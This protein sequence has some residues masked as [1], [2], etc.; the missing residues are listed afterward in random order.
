MSGAPL[1]EVSD[2]PTGTTSSAPPVSEEQHSPHSYLE[3]W[4]KSQSAIKRHL[5]R[6]HE[7]IHPHYIQGDLYTGATRAFWFDSLSAFYPGLLTLMGEVDEA[8]E[9]HLLTTALWNRYSALPERWSTSSGAVEGGLAWWSGRPEFIESTYHLYRATLDPWYLHVGEMTLRDIKRRCW[10]KCGW[11]GI[12]DVRT[13][14][15]SDRMESFFL[16]ETAKY[17]FLLFDPGHPLNKLDAPFVFSTEGHPLILPKP[18]SR[19]F[20]TPNRNPTQPEPLYD[21]VIATCPLPPPS[22]PFSTSATAARKDLY[23]AA[24]LARLHLMPTP[25]TVESPIVEYSRDHPS[26]SVSDIRSPSNYTYFPWTLPLELVPHDGMCSKITAKTSFDITF[27]SSPNTVLGP[28]MLQRVLNGV[29]VNSMGGVR[30]G[31]IQDVPT[32]AGSELNREV[33]RVHAIN[34]ILLGKDERVFLAKDTAS[35]VVSPLDPNFTRVRDPLMLDIV[36]D[37]ADKEE[38]EVKQG[39]RHPEDN[40]SSSWGQQFNLGDALGENAGETSAIMVAFNS[41]LQQITGLIRE[42][43]PESPQVPARKYIAAIIPTGAG[44]APLPDVDD[45]LGP[46]V[47]GSPQG[48]L[49]W[50][51]IYVA[52][53]NC[54]SR[55]PTDIPRHHQ[56]IVV[57][58]GGCS[59]TQKL[60]NIPIHLP[61]ESSLQLVIVVSEE[62][63]DPNLPRGYLIRPWLE[64]AQ[65]SASGLPRH[66]PIPMVMVGGGKQTYDLFKGAL[67]LGVKRRY[68]MQARGVPISNLIVI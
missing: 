58:R 12:Q 55:L 18:K 17:L 4:Q 3:V 67:G 19:E 21:P 23:H 2:V 1:P 52:G 39:G 68:T 24:N 60:Q 8:A 7:F 44:A 57:M 6:G 28:G 62:E 5:Y 51:T 34:N 45:S 54:K 26:I 46:D 47:S 15:L 49:L 32:V 13:G 61:S 16:G 31:M 41:I 65:H 37:I 42:A 38:A 50:N 66:N 10:A 9:T 56:V 36:I 22:V 48:S 35:K 59:F 27:P 63:E 53:D 33:Y 11:A 64:T 29:L 25:E 30:F 14:E 20:S 40:A 43:S